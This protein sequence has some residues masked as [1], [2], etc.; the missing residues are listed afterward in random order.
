ML[1]LRSINSSKAAVLSTA[2]VCVAV[3]VGVDK[4]DCWSLKRMFE[5]GQAYHD[6]KPISQIDY[7]AIMYG[8]SS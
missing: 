3:L 4:L 2:R 5:R 7:E 8:K 6:T 1:V